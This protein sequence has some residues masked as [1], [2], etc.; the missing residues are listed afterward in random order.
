MADTHQYN[1]YEKLVRRIGYSVGLEDIVD[2]IDKLVNLYVAERDINVALW[3]N[4]VKEGYGRKI[5]DELDA[6]KWGGSRKSNKKLGAEDHFADFYSELNLLYRANSQ[7]FPLYGLEILSIIKRYYNNTS[8][9]YKALKSIILL[10]ILEADGDIFLNCLIGNFEKEKTIDALCK[11]FSTKKSKYMNAYVNT[12]S[13]NKLIPIFKVQT[14]GKNNIFNTKTNQETELKIPDDYISKVI[15]TRKGWAI[16]L[17]LYQNSIEKPGIELL[18]FLKK[19]NIC[20]ESFSTFY[21]YSETHKTLFI[22]EEKMEIVPISKPEF[23]HD[24]LN[25]RLREDDKQLIVPKHNEIITLLIKIMELYKEGN[26]VKGVIRH[27]LP[28]QIL[29]PTFYVI[30]AL[31]GYVDTD[32]NE[33]IKEEQKSSERKLDMLHLRGT[34]IE[35]AI[36]IRT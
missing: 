22:D 4:L 34:E 1:Q 20:H 17:G 26:K 13:L 2:R 28:L 30:T 7:I 14:S 29:L 8:L 15:P 11:M 33:F 16:Q 24:F 36:T 25:F 3:K 10:F 31:D 5:S 35:G 18:T 6:A 23:I 21:C 19:M 12:F 32:L 27:Q 9:Y